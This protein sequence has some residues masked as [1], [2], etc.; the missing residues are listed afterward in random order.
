MRRGC[1]SLGDIKCDGCRKMIPAYDRYLV[2]QEVDGKEED[3]GA[4]RFY[5]VSCATKKGYAAVK[6]EKGER[7]LTFFA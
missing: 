7:M 2:I 4:T 5:C 6:E 3:K 1:I